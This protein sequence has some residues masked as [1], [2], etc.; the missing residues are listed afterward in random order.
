MDGAVDA[1]AAEQRAVRRI[2]DRR[3]V[4][5]RDVGDADVQLRRS[6]LGGEEGR[7]VM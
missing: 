2:D 6:D 1:A 3:G 4:E 7:W 5:R